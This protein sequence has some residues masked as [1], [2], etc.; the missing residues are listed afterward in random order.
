MESE[1]KNINAEAVLICLGQKIKALRLE[2]NWTQ[3]KFAEMAKINDKEVSHIEAG[4]RNI[5]IE[6][7]VKISN[8]FGM[9]PYKLLVENKENNI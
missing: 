9:E 8:S 5:T 2:R 4:R 3:E 1:Q 7:L 6:T